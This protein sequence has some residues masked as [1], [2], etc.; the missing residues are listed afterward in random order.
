M[1]SIPTVKSVNMNT[2]EKNLGV[3]ATLDEIREELF[4][5]KSIIIGNAKDHVIEK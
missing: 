5:G 1:E 2:Q 4:E 3:N